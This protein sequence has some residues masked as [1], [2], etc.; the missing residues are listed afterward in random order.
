ML[1][2]SSPI[3]KTHRG[4]GGAGTHDSPMNQFCFIIKSTFY[5]VEEWMVEES[6][7]G[8]PR[9]GRS[10]E[11]EN[12]TSHPLRATCP[13]ELAL[14]AHTAALDKRVG[15]SRVDPSEAFYNIPTDHS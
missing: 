10:Y 1:S 9:V 3:T 15:Q 2:P 13:H 12:E 4:E 6:D 5:D 8:I 11:T 14:L 7:V